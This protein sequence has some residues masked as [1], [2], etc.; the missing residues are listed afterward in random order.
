M[1]RELSGI[2]VDYHKQDVS[3]CMVAG[4]ERRA[5]YQNAQSRR[6]GRKRGYCSAHKALASS[7]Y[8]AKTQESKAAWTLR[9]ID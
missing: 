2:K 9:G 7:S 6:M 3:V 1:K 4:C 5:L 8:S